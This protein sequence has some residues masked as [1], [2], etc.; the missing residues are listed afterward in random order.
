MP[1]FSRQPPPPSVRSLPP[2]PDEHRGAAETAARLLCIYGEALFDTHP[3]LARSEVDRCD[4]WAR[5]VRHAAPKG[6][7]ATDNQRV[8]WAE[9]VRFFRDVRQQEAH[10]VTTGLRELSDAV[11]TL[12][13]GFSTST[14]DSRSADDELATALTSLSDALERSDPDALREAC[15]CV[16]SQIATVGARRH[17]TFEAQRDSL[18]ARISELQTGTF[19]KDR[20]DVT[21]RLPTADALLE[22]LEFMATIGKLM[23]SPPVLVLFAVDPEAAP[24]DACVRAVADEALRTF[25][26]RE[27]YVARAGETLVAAVLP[28]TALSQALSSVRHALDKLGERL[29]GEPCR[30][31]ASVTTLVPG[32]T[33]RDWWQRAHGILTEE[34]LDGSCRTPAVPA[35][36]E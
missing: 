2:S 30:L 24:I 11:R 26:S 22:H 29:A 17:G 35:T 10:T 16:V 9:L 31:G 8:N 3:E 4:E 12:A 15:E 23:E 7:E 36:F 13:K 21:T 34:P 25:L 14:L 18:R 1:F 6:D 27:Q 28:A 32:E 19:E 33:A 20:W 5:K